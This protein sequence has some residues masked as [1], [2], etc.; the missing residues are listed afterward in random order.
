L[1]IVPR[2]WFDIAALVLLCIGFGIPVHLVGNLQFERDFVSPHSLAVQALR[3]GSHKNHQQT[4]A[5]ALELVLAQY[6][7]HYPIQKLHM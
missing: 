6:W 3:L 1:Y 5:L 4:Q 7:E 2:L